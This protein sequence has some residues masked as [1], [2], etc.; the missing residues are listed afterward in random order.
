MSFDAPAY[1]AQ[2]APVPK[3]PPVI[4]NVTLPPEQTLAL[5]AASVGAVDG[6]FT[7]SLAPVLEA[8]LPAAFV[9]THVYVAASPALTVSIVNVSFVIPL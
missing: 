5:L 2:L 7:V 6:I 3:V 8:T 4:V 9:T 1:T